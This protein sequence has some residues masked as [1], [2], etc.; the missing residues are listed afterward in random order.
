MLALLRA[1]R[2]KQWAKN[3][4][5]LAPLIFSRQAL[6]LDSVFETGWVFLSFS[7]VASTIY[8]IN[9]LRD[10]ESDRAH[11][12]KK[13]RPIASGTVGVGTA[14]VT[15]IVLGLGALALG[16][17]QSWPVF[18]VIATYLV[19]NTSYTF[20]LKQIVLVDIFI[21]AIGFVLRVMAGAAA[22]EVVASQWI[23]TCTLFLA[24]LLAACKRR[25]EVEA[26][27]ASAGTRMV[28][29]RYST[30]Y[31]DV[32]IAIVA[33]GAIL[34]YAL[35]AMSPATVEH[36]GTS[37]LIFTLPFVV[38]A[39]FRYIYL[40]LEQTQGE[41]PFDLLVRDGTIWFNVV[42][43]LVVTFLIVYVL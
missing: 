7:M 40:V 22:I 39:V 38:F 10:R 9:D 19:L 6:E 23:L 35:Y 42:G 36:I 31:L 5:C 11:P 34:S 24:L 33:G 14:V 3:S 17:L 37:D 20:K 15:A 41:S 29:S 8:L 28:L 2:P 1:L 32:I 12:V 13:M 4:F 21:I 18:A 43:Y 26:Q 16:F 30:K 27:G 25:A